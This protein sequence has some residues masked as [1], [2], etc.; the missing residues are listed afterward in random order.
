M[1]GESE[2]GME[3]SRIERLYDLLDMAEREKGHRIS[4]SITLGNLYIGTGGR[5]TYRLS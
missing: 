2:K 4:N 5:I 1:Q 3:K